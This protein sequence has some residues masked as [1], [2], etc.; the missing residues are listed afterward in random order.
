M[1][2]LASIIENMWVFF[3][4]LILRSLN[5]GEPFLSHSETKYNPDPPL[6]MYVRR[7]HRTTEP[8]KKI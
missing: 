4:E 6:V 2:R 3:S 1:M 7:T 5:D 8:N